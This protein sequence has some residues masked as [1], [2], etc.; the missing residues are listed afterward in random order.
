[1]LSPL[2]VSTSTGKI[3]MFLALFISFFSQ[4]SALVVTK[5]CCHVFEHRGAMFGPELPS[6]P[7]TIITY[8]PHRK[9]IS[10]LEGP[11]TLTYQSNPILCG[12]ILHSKQSFKDYIVLVPRGGCS[13]AEKVYNAQLLD[14]KAVIIYQLQDSRRSFSDLSN[15]DVIVMAEDSKYGDLVEIPSIFIS[16]NSWKHIATLLTE[17][18]NPIS[19]YYQSDDSD[20]TLSSHNRLL[21]TSD[22]DQVILTEDKI[23]VTN[24]K[25]DSNKFNS[26]HNIFVVINATGSLRTTGQDTMPL[27]WDSLVFLIKVFVIIWS[28][29]GFAYVSNW[30]KMKYNK[31][32]R[33]NIIKTLPCKKYKTLQ[34][35][36]NKK[37]MKVE[38][39]EKLKTKTKGKYSKLNND[40]TGN[41]DEEHESFNDL[42]NGE[43]EVTLEEFNPLLK[44]QN[45]DLKLRNSP[46]KSSFQ[47]TSTSVKSSNSSDT[48]SSSSKNKNSSA[49]SSLIDCDNCVICLCEFD[50][51][52]N[53][54]VMPC[55]HIYHQDCIKP[56]LINK[57]S[58]CPICKRSIFK[59]GETRSLSEIN[60]AEEDLQLNENGQNENRRGSTVLSFFMFLIVM[61]TFSFILADDGNDSGGG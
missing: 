38:K 25:L 10:S 47:D 39:Q 14:A 24:R 36:S 59:N 11:I 3:S 28:I 1:M 34:F 8:K 19:S 23:R 51:D 49:S 61:F 53:V 32:K 52:D 18:E 22:E 44:H 12:N 50:L 37:S 40:E 58:L 4:L 55:K 41:N 16:H 46:K 6:P 2:D 35:H 5:P 9:K 43:N 60:Q 7:S 29:M 21:I 15:D 13:F 33:E 45:S 56:W 17:L 27:M 26:D 31:Y 57:S 20:S 30:V 48:E 54:I 42:E